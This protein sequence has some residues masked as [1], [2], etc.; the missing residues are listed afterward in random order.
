M[1]FDQSD[2]RILIIGAN[3]AGKTVLAE[4]LS[5][6]Y[7][8]KHIDLDRIFWK[9]GWVKSTKEEFFE[10][11]KSEL[12]LYKEWIVDGNYYSN[13]G[14]LV[15]KDANVII[16]LDYNI[17]LVGRRVIARTI[18]NIVFKKVLFDNNYD[19]LRRMIT[20]K[21]SIIVWSLK[22]YSRKRKKYNRIYENH[23]SEEVKFLRFKKP[24]ETEEFLK[25]LEEVF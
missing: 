11:V 19:S 12:S 17:G 14:E 3:G 16:W 22:T 20:P 25:R 23:F 18:K 13:V 1:V 2:L 4:K 24:K 7:K 8:I 6:H 10:N 21:D 5:S 9:P 15:W